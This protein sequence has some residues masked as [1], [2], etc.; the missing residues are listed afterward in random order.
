MDLLKRVLCT[1]VLVGIGFIV[2]RK[3]VEEKTVIKY[4][5]L[6]PIQGEVKVPDLVPKWEGFRNPIKLIHIYK[7]QEEKVPQTPPEITNGGGF[8]EDQKEV[9]TLE[10]VKRTILDWNTTR[11]YAGTFFKDPKIGQFDWEATV[12]YNTLQHLTYKYIPVREQIKETRSPKWSPFLRASAN[13]F[14]QVG[15][16]GGIY[17]RNFGVDISY[18]RDFELTRSGYEIGFSWKF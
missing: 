6:P 1:I 7:G 13:S 10:S 2:G 16:G 12:Q 17:Y 3:T 9:D 8:G 14:G 15:A 18:M 11:K 5:D 4:V